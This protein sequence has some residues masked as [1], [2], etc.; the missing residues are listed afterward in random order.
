MREQTFE[1]ML[2]EYGKYGIGNS[3]LEERQK[4]LAEY[5]Y[6][7]IVEGY[8]EEF[9]SLEQWMDENKWTKNNEL[10]VSFNGVYYGKTGY[11]YGF[12][13]YFVNEE[14]LLDT[15]RYAVQHIYTIHEVSTCK[16]DGYSNNVILDPNDKHAMVYKLI[17]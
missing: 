16:S 6:S 12:L 13:E 5:K 14:M 1:N 11:D 17:E 3:L 2:I 9:D 15:L 8:H 7:I 4:Y 10:V